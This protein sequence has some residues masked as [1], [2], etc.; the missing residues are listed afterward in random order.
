MKRYLVSTAAIATLT[1]A[2]TF[3]VA[4]PAAPPAPQPKPAAAPAAKPE[5]HPEI[6]NALE[7]LR[8]AR[9]HLDHA[10]HDF[11]GHRVEAIRSIDEAIRQL[12][13]CMQYER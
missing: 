13:I 5:P 12:K 1:L 8:V 6:R 2:L 10:A 4:V 9:E 7:S 11:G 3:P